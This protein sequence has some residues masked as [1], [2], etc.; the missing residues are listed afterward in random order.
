MAWKAKTLRLHN[1]EPKTRGN[2]NERGY[3]YRWQKASKAY[4]KQNPV[5]V[6]HLAKGEVVAW[7]ICKETGKRDGLVVDHIIPH[8]GDMAVFWDR[9]NWQTLCKPCHDLKTARYDVNYNPMQ[10]RK[11][12]VVCGEPGSGKTTWIESQRKPGDLVYDMD[13]LA[14]AMFQCPTYPRPPHV[15]DAMA[16]LRD[17]CVAQANAMHCDAYLIVTDEREAIEVAEAINGKVVRMDR[18]L[19]SRGS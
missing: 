10:E 5:C 12:I 2:A 19:W 11:R 15:F 8:R 13:A 17:W 18:S 16:R 4:L 9:S 6:L 1:R 7:T 3:T 14:G